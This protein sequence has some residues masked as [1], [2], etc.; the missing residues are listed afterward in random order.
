MYPAVCYIVWPDGTYVAKDDYVE[1][2]WTHKSDDYLAVWV[3]SNLSDDEIASILR[4][5]VNA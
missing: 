5:V 1:S 2:D 3:D 4:R